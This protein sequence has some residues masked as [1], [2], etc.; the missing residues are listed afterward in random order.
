MTN[1]SR[2]IEF[3]CKKNKIDLSRLADEIKVDFTDIRRPGPNELAKI[4]E[5]FSLS[6]DNLINGNL[7]KINE[8][9]TKN[10]KLLVLDVDGV[11]TDAGMYYSEKGDEFKKFNARDGLMIRR[12]TSSGFQVAI[13]SNGF[14]E[15]LVKSRA[16]LLGIQNVH[17]GSFKKVDVLA[18]VCT[19]L[20]I[21][22]QEVAFIGDDVNDEELMNKIALAV[23][24]SDAIEKIK[25]TAHLILNKKGGEGCVREF[26]DDYLSHLF[27]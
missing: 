2:N 12:L 24:P 20:K 10:I 4:A 7:Y 9:D 1:Y 5:H 13:L 6:L 17:V 8:I 18:E 14:N 26:I 21:T 16:A 15:N 11:L 23:C 19:K 22:F 3:L 25:N 27:V